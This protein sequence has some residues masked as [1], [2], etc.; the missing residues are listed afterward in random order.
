MCALVVFLQHAPIYAIP[1]VQLQNHQLWEVCY[2]TISEKQKRP[3]PIK[4]TWLKN[5]PINNEIMPLTKYMQGAI[6]VGMTH[7]KAM[8][9]NIIL[10]NKMKF[11]S[12]LATII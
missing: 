8:S 4:Y 9:S 3:Q 11:Y 5:S 1:S 7:C 10:T 12:N 6:Q 2:E